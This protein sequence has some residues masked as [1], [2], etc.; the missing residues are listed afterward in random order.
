MDEEEDSRIYRL[1]EFESILREMEENERLEQ[2]GL[3]AEELVKKTN[4]EI[5]PVSP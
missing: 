1:E 3:P 2:E 4:L 5:Y